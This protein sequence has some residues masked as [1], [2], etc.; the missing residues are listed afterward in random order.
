MKQYLDLM[1]HVKEQGTKKEDRTGTGTISVFGYQMRFDLSDGFPL[2]TTKKC[3]LKSIIHELLWF[4]QGDTNIK[5]LKDNGVNIWNGW[6]TEEGELGP[7]YGKQWRSWSGLDGQVIDQIS[8]L[9]EQ[10]KTNP[11]SR[12]LIISAWNPAVLPDT[13]YSPSENAAMGK[14]ALPPCHTLF[15]FYVLDGKLSCQLYQRSADILLGVPFNI[16]SYALLTMML[17]QVC[18]LELGDFV[19][20]FGDAHLY[21]NHMEQVDE[22]LSRTPFSLPTM[23][24]N[25]DVKDIFSF[26]FEDFILENYDSHAA[27]KAPIAI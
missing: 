9:V 16:A 10:I 15:Q 8:E 26:K 19:H 14:Q 6:A 13:N 22:Q 3:H 20:T 21:L 25:P 5:Y 17:A 23:S 4:L 1:R 2:V 11:D 18:D 12:R 24:I 27:I 7:V